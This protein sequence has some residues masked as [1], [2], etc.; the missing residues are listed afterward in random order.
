L[1]LSSE[2]VVV[3]VSSLSIPRDSLMSNRLWNN[4]FKNLLEVVSLLSVSGMSSTGP[5]AVE[6]PAFFPHVDAVCGKVGRSNV[7]PTDTTARGG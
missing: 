4:D 5:M 2:Q 7:G 3:T 6:A 1:S